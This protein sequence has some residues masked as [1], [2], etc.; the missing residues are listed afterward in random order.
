MKLLKLI[1]METWLAVL[2]AVVCGLIAYTYQKGVV[3]SLVVAVS[4][5]SLVFYFQDY[6]KRLGK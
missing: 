3:T 6:R 1:F 5:L 4:A 2:A